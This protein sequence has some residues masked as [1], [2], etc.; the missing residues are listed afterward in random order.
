MQIKTKGKD[1]SK[2]LVLALLFVKALIKI[3]MEYFN[4]SDVFLAENA[5]ELPK[6]S[7]MNNYAI[8]PKK[9]KQSLFS[10]IYSL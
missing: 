2:A 4:Y 5:I 3:L 9:D 6:Y 1:Q 8:N 10:K 7:K